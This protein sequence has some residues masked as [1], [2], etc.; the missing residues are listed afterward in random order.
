MLTP[1]ERYVQL[2]PHIIAATAQQNFT[3]FIIA[4]YFNK[5]LFIHFSNLTRYKHTV[6]YS[7]FNRWGN[8][9]RSVEPEQHLSLSA[10]VTTDSGMSQQRW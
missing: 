7:A 5:R 2:I 9:A 1:S 3:G 10:A 6:L 8:R 4:F